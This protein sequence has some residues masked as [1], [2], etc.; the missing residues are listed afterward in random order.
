LPP[1]GMR[2]LEWLMAE[3]AGRRFEGH[4]SADMPVL[5]E[6]ADVLVGHFTGSTAGGVGPQRLRRLP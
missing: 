4:E 6:G 1:L 2:A 5:G 3:P